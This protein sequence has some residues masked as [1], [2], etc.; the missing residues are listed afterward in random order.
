MKRRDLLR[1]LR[2]HDCELLREGSNH[3]VYVNPQNN[4]KAPVPRHGEISGFTARAVCDQLKI[5]R[6]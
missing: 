2:A 3:S 4:R 1:H 6:P 5:P